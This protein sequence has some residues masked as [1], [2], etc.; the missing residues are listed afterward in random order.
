MRWAWRDH[1]DVP[2]SMDMRQIHGYSWSMG[3]IQQLGPWAACR[4][5][6]SLISH[7]WKRGRADGA[8]TRAWLHYLSQ[9][10]TTSFLIG[11]IQWMYRL[12]R[13]VL[14][15]LRKPSTVHRGSLDNITLGDYGAKTNNKKVPSSH[16]N[17]NPSSAL[18]FDHKYLVMFSAAL[19]AADNREATG[20]DD[21]EKRL[22]DHVNPASW[23][24]GRLGSH[25]GHYYPQIAFGHLV[26]AVLPKS[27]LSGKETILTSAS[28]YPRSQ[29]QLMLLG[30]IGLTGPN[31]IPL[32]L[33]S[34][35]GRHV[36]SL[37]ALHWSLSVLPIVPSSWIPKKRRCCSRLCIT[38]L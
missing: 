38:I 24:I 33:Q 23:S 14:L 8:W 12:P 34:S 15:S 32:Q 9:L 7:A 10:N 26:L 3:T 28:E 27:L 11:G 22:S 2:I 5:L 30:Q 17:K 31:R 19:A 29:F 18:S 20:M 37:W 35:L 4:S 6:F 16:I 1:Q 25:T 21:V 13:E 36:F